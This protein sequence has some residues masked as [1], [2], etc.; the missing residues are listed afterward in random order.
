M[1]WDAEQIA[2]CKIVLLT[3]I[4]KIISFMLIGSSFAACLP[5]IFLFGA[6]SLNDTVRSETALYCLTEHNPY[7]SQLQTNM[8]INY[9]ENCW[10]VDFVNL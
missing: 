5:R 10:S 7:H 2:L 9:R 8:N 1:V 4:H 6:C 3:I